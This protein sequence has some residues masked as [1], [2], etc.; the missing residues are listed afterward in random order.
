MSLLRLRE[1]RGIQ[2]RHGV[3]RVRSVGFD[4]GE[5][6]EKCALTWYGSRTV[7][8]A[9]SQRYGGGDIGASCGWMSEVR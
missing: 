2:V 8:L 7:S 9:A 6:F 4:I 3:Y 1:I 5:G